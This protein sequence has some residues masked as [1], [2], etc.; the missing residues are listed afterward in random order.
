MKQRFTEV[1]KIT[2]VLKNVQ[3]NPIIPATN[4]VPDHVTMDLRKR[5]HQSSFRANS[6]DRKKTLLNYILIPIAPFRN[7][8]N[9]NFNLALP[10]IIFQ[11]LVIILILRKMLTLQKVLKQRSKLTCIS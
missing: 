3:N 10:P 2:T 5:S 6:R 7:P 11:N 1:T 8:D 9:L 4:L